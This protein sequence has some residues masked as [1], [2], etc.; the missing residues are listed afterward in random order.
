MNV[1][2]KK[3]PPRFISKG[4]DKDKKVNGEGFPYQ[5]E[6]LPPGEKQKVL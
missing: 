1:K 5:A 3:K 4:T 2:K 6:S